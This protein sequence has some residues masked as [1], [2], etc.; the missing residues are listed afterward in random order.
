MCAHKR[1]MDLWEREWLPYARI[2]RSGGAHVCVYARARVDSLRLVQLGCTLL[3][4]GV[5][6]SLLAAYTRATRMPLCSL[7]C[8]LLGVGVL[9]SLL[10]AF[11]RATRM[12]LMQHPSIVGQD[13]QSFFG[14]FLG[15]IWPF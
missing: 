8:T 9:R 10:A 13:L 1:R 14:S 11:T 3:G 4:V 15:K 2:C 5:L 12:P 7:G 6:R